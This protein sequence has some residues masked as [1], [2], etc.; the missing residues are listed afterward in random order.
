MLSIHIKILQYIS[1]II[2]HYEAIRILLQTVVHIHGRYKQSHWCTSRTKVCSSRTKHCFILN[3]I[4]KSF[5]LSLLSRTFNDVCHFCKWRRHKNL[6]VE[7]RSK[8][9]ITLCKTKQSL[10]RYV[11]NLVETYVNAIVCSDCGSGQLFVKGF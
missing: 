1:T 10:V 7:G 8:D 2:E 5:D 11:Q 9:F 6:P 4:E 3:Y